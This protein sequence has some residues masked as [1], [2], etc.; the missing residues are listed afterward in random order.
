MNLKQLKIIN[1]M[2]CL[3]HR[4]GIVYRETISENRKSYS[5]HYF[6]L[7]DDNKLFY[8]AN[9]ARLQRVLRTCSNAS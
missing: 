8:M 5:I 9:L 1:I 6:F 2:Y 7:D 3:Y 4:I